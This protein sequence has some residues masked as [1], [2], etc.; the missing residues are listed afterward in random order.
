[1]TV[2]TTSAT[3]PDL[4]NINLVASKR[5]SDGPEWTA[6][7]SFTW[8][9]GLPA[10]SKSGR[11]R[12]AQA[13]AQLDI[14][15]NEIRQI[16]KPTISISGL[17][18]SLFEEPLGQQVLVNTVPVSRRGN[19]GLVQGK[20]TIPTKSAVSI[21]VSV[22]W[23]SRTELIRESDVRGNIGISLDLDKLFAKGETKQ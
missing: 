7:A 18:L 20:L 8:F 21:P 13:S 6:N 23:A 19:I 15:L 3:L 14:P 4:S 10:G 11:I 1:M 5:F 9:Q 22:T 2:S 17:F 16:G 12:D